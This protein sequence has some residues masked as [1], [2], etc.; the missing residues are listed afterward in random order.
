MNCPNCGADLGAGLL[1]AR[2]PECGK[3]LGEASERGRGTRDSAARAAASRAN[4]E[5]LSGMGRGRIRSG[6]TVKRVV[7]VIVGAAIAAAFCVIVY[8]VAY[9]AELIGGRSVPNVVG[10]RAEKAASELETR[11]FSVATTEV[12]SSEQSEG[13]VVSTN[14]P[15]GTRV[16]AGGVVT[17]DVVAASGA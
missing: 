15:A 7:R 11:G 9:Q 12:E 10:W 16:E 4:V 3:A 13:M 5:G 6:N 2:C 8:V 1:P 17:I 14:P